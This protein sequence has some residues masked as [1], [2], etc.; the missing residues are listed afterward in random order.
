MN[1]LVGRK[2]EIEYLQQIEESEEPEFVAVYG[3]RR[4]GKTFLIREFFSN[5][6]VFYFSGSENANMK[7]QLENFRNAYQEY[8]KTL[9]PT[10]ENWTTAFAMLKNLD[11]S[12][13]DFGGKLIKKHTY[14]Q[15]D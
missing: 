12:L 6:F 4:V 2:K 3:R 7:T 9:I 11:L 13:F 10:P 8:F 1:K 14:R 5:N 15:N